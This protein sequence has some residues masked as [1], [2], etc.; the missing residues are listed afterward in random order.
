LTHVLAALIYVLVTLLLF[1]GLL[2]HLNTHLSPDPGDPLLNATI[3]A[4]NARHVPLSAEWWN[5]HRL[6]AV[7]T[8]PRVP[9]PLP[10]EPGTWPVEIP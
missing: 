2:P 3:L 4:W 1:R 5:V 10:R 9:L 6:P 8:L 7:G